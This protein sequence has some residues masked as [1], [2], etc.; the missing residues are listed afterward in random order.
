M[1]ASLLTLLRLLKRK[2]P[3][4]Y[5]HTRRVARITARFLTRTHP[6]L[7]EEGR[8]AGRSVFAPLG[9]SNPHDLGKLALPQRLL[10]K[11]TYLSPEERQ[12][13]EA[14]PRLGAHLLEGLSL[15]SFILDGVLYHHER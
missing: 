10:T 11:P 4:T 5:M 3:A 15:S 8:L 1:H 6:H 13:L 2:D 9:R 14:H 7:A 12:V